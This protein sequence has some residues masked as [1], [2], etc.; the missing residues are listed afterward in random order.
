M[1]KI[2]PSPL[3]PP[4]RGGGHPLLRV[5][6]RRKNA[7]APRD[8]GYSVIVPTPGD[9]P[10]EVFVMADIGETPEEAILRTWEA[11]PGGVFPPPAPAPGNINATP[12][13]ELGGAVHPPSNTPLTPA[14]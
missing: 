8:T 1:T 2:L 6:T 3:P 9:L 14:R 5:G 7:G 12:P 13:A 4:T 10:Q 11:W